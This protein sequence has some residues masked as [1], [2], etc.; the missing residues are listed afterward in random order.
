MFEKVSVLLDSLSLEEFITV[1]YSDGNVCAA[2]IMADKDI[3]EFVQSSKN[4]IGTD[5]NEENEMN[6]AAPVYTSSEMRNII[7]SMH[8]YLDAHSNGGMNN[9][10]IASNN[11]LII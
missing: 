7:K 10:W 8:S 1:D 3:L 4:I 2:P 11:L 6:N 9:K 5:S